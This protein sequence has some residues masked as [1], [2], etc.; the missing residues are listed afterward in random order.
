VAFAI[1]AKGDEL[2]AQIA[3]F[4]PEQIAEQCAAFGPVLKEHVAALSLKPAADVL[5]GRRG[6]SS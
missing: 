6:L 3:S 4:T 5:A 2:T 1:D